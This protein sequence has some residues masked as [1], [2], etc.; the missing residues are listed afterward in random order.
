MKL[1]LTLSF[2]IVFLLIRNQ[3][4]A[5][6]Y[7]KSNEELIFSFQTKNHKQVYLVKEKSNK[8]ICYR[9]GSKE[10]VEF[11]YPTLNK[12]SWNQFKYSFYLRGGGISNEGM[13]LNY[14]Y[15]NNNG[16]KYVIYYTYYARGN[17]VEVGIRVIDLKTNKTIS[18]IKG[19]PKARKGS[20]F[21]FRDNNLLKIED[22][23]FN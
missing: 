8:Y 22:E 16:Y 2:F 7:I 17:E 6:N 20:L 12:E 11:E 3:S 19:N 5:Q 23:T 10:R 18:D 13:D 9:F 15:F 21:G 4:F 1:I 14:V